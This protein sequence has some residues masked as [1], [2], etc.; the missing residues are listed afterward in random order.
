MRPG[1]C[2]ISNNHGLKGKDMKHWR[3]LSLILGGMLMGIQ[4]EETPSP[5]KDYRA[6][7]AMLHQLGLPE[8]TKDAKY[9][10]TES[11]SY[12][13][14]SALQAMSIEMDRK[15][16]LNG[17]GW[18]LEDEGKGRAKVIRNFSKV[19]Y[20]IDYD[21]VD[22]TSGEALNADLVNMHDS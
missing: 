19:E 15:A 8:A 21:K 4:A 3:Q 14:Y 2:D 17:S 18:L 10:A 12:L 20:I 7:F 22:E 6:G 5:V 9:I 16:P 11:G 1:G 13:F